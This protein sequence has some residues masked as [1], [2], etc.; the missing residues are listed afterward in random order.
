MIGFESIITNNLDALSGITLLNERHYTSDIPGIS[1]KYNTLFGNQ[2][3]ISILKLDMSQYKHKEQDDVIKLFDDTGLIKISNVD[4]KISLITNFLSN[5]TNYAVSLHYEDDNF[6]LYHD[7]SI[8]AMETLLTSTLY[9]INYMSKKICG[10]EEIM[11]IKYSLVDNRPCIKTKGSSLRKI[12]SVPGVD[13]IHTKS[14]GVKDTFEALGIEAAVHVFVKQLEMCVSTGSVSQ[15][16][17]DFIRIISNAISVN[18]FMVGINKNGMDKI[19][20]AFFT[21]LSFEDHIGSMSKT[22]KGE[23]SYLNDVSSCIITGTSLPKL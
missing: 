16:N 12:L 9:D 18:G 15:Q 1:N 10:I 11:E 17:K 2:D 8:E 6:Y 21:L 3:K 5:H 22:Y 23:I 14:D 19:D 13:V 7:L 4:E 20:G